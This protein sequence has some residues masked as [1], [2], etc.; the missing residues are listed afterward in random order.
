MGERG[1]V[2]TVALLATM[3][4]VGMG[5][6]ML[7]VSTATQRD[8]LAAQQRANRR[9]LAQSGVTQS[10]LNMVQGGD[11]RLGTKQAPVAWGAGTLR[12]EVVDSG[13]KTYT[14]TSYGRAGTSSRALRA[15]GGDVPVEDEADGPLHD[16][17]RENA[18]PAELLGEARVASRPGVLQAYVDHVRLGGLH[19]DRQSG[20]RDRASECP[21]PVVVL[22]KPRDPVLERM[23]PAGGEHAG[24]P[25]PAPEELPDPAAF[26]DR[27]AASAEDRPRGRSEALREAEHH[28]VGAGGEVAGGNP[29]S[30]LGV[31]DAGA[32]HVELEALLAAGLAGAAQVLEGKDRSSG[33]VARL[34][35]DEERGPGEMD[36]FSAH[37][38]PDRLHGNR[39]A[40]PGERRQLD[41]PEPGRAR[42]LEVEAVSERLDEDLVARTGGHRDGDGVRHR[43]RRDEEGAFFSEEFRRSLL[44]PPHGGII[45]EDIIPQRSL[46]HG[47]VH[48]LVG[49]CDRVAAQVDGRRRGL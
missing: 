26:P 7:T 47:R 4:V 17:Y 27:I 24:L 41:P 38:A 20:R 33:E 25:H 45:A 23:E 37:G 6:S 5:V 46:D 44:E 35:Q 49:A 31:E 12:A 21:G 13:N 8:H 42:H 15:V 14:I 40:D 28:G 3:V 34:L 22:G 11:G 43:P 2:M 16:R 10:I 18:R 19:R 9:Y 29:G 32:V 1:S 39:S 30:N 36:V 48:V